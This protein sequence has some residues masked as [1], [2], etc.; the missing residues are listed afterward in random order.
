MGGYPNILPLGALTKSSSMMAL[1]RLFS[2]MSSTSSSERSISSLLDDDD[3]RCHVHRFQLVAFHWSS[4]LSK[5]ISMSSFC[6]EAF[7]LYHLAAPSLVYLM[8]A[9]DFFL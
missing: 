1:G 6:S 5:Q 4:L 9:L 3:V 2:L 7:W 8:N